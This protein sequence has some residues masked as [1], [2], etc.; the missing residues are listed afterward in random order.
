MEETNSALVRSVLL[1]CQVWR[2][3]Y[4]NPYTS[5]RVWINAQVLGTFG[6]RY[7]HPS[8]VEGYDLEPYLERAGVLPSDGAVSSHISHRLRRLGIDYYQTSAEVQKRYLIKHTEVE[9]VEH[10]GSSL[11]RIEEARARFRAVVASYGGVTA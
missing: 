2:D 7:G 5:A 6:Y 8:E 11:R 10:F 9:P 3:S 4:A 1:E